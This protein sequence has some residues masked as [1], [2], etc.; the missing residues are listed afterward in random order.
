MKI[1]STYSLALLA[2]TGKTLKG[3]GIIALGTVVLNALAAEPPTPVNL[4]EVQQSVSVIGKEI[5]NSQ[6]QKAEPP[7]DVD[8]RE[9]QQ[10]LSVIGMEIKDS[11]DQKLGRVKDLALDLEKGRLVEV[12]V[13]SGGFLGFGQRTVAVPPGAF[14]FDPTGGVLRLNVDKEKF[15]AA[16]DFAMSKWAEHCQSRHVAEAYRYYGQTPYFAAD[17]Q[18]SKSGNT[19]T[20]PL[21]YVQ[22]SSELLGL[23]VKNRQNEPLGNVNTFLFDLLSGRG[24]GYVTHVIVRDY[25]FLKTKSVIPAR[26]LRFNATHDALYLDVSA[27]AFKNEPRFRWTHKNA[28]RFMWTYGSSGPVQHTPENEPHYYGQSSPFQQAY[29][30][31]PRFEARTRDEKGPFQQE[32]Y[33]NTKVAANDGVNTR[34]NVQEGTANTYT[35]LVQGTSFRDVEKTYQI[36][37]AMRADASLSRNAQNVEVGTLNGRVTLRGHVNTEEG[38]RVIGEI[39]AKAGLALPENVSNLLEVR[40]LP[41]TSK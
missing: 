18:D 31:E 9:V 35:P 21:G 33:S 5:K 39:A 26:A 2:A 38:K 25:G 14:K 32:T 17:G 7:P 10:S 40:P 22:R 19:A 36:Y 28:P 37:A 11:Q 29:E 20:E 4:R 13:A 6:D 15:K 12:I 41:G 24:R 34:Q 23:P 16:P 8:F 27:Q 3:L 1:K 30:N